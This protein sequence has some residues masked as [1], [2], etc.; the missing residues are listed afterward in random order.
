MENQARQIHVAAADQETKELQATQ[1]KIDSVFSLQKE[2]QWEVRKTSAGERIK[3]LKLLR[4]A[5]HEHARDIQN[6]I[7]NDFRKPPVETDITEIFIL[8]MEI[9]HT[10][11]HL[12]KWMRPKKVPTPLSFLGSKSWVTYEPKGVSLIITPWNFP[13]LLAMDPLISAIA[14]G[15]CV[16]MKPSELSPHTS[17][18]IKEMLGRLFPESEVAVFEGGHRI[19]QHLLKKPFD[20]IF[21]IGG[22]RV[23]RIVMEAAA[24]HLSSVTLELGGK[25][26]AIIHYSAN[27]KEAARK[28]SF[29]RFMNAGQAC[30]AVDYVLL[31]KHLQ[32][33]FVDHLIKEVSR[34]Y[35]QSPEEIRKNGFVAHIINPGHFFRLKSMFDD[36]VNRGARVRF[37][38]YFDQQDRFISPTVLTDVSPDADI[39]Q[40]EIF[41]PLLP[42]L[43]YE[44]FEEAIRFVKS[45]P[46][47][48]NAYIFSRDNKSTRLALN[49]VPCGTA[50]VN[51]A[52]SQFA[53]VNLPFGGINESGMGNAHGFYGF[54]A[55]SHEKP[56]MKSPR[57]PSIELF[58]PPYTPRV[59]KLVQLAIRWLA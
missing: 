11:R 48:L 35:G 44:D 32:E 50:C 46:K 25:S 28:I 52:A 42:V 39:M 34:S 23:G 30:V 51:D 38:G 10:I 55:F 9:N 26:P 43:T 18:L 45:R 27:L 31:P 59:K 7:Y 12:R 5:I 2:H 54:R 53:Q 22:S 13:F 47:P 24:K 8:T 57:H 33:P 1:K 41:G 49:Q 14:A 3:K 56:V 58:Y 21:Y 20:H 4:A 6:A 17:H 16:M 15:N 29:G 36:A 37:G 19:A 40:E